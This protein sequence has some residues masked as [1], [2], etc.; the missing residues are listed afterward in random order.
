MNNNKV[1]TKSEQRKIVYEDRRSLDDFGCNDEGSLNHI[2]YTKWLRYRTE[3]D[4]FKES[5]TPCYLKVFN[6]A[7]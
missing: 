4:A 3:I 2:I 6:D 1:I 7:F 5:Q